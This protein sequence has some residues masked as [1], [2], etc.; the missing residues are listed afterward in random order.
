MTQSLRPAFDFSSEWA[1]GEGFASDPRE[2]EVDPPRS[3]ATFN[4]AHVDSMGRTALMRAAKVG[5]YGDALGL[6]RAGAD[7][8]ALDQVGR[9]ALMLAIRSCAGDCVRLLLPVTK[10]DVRNLRGQSAL[11]LARRSGRSDI[12]A[13][14][15]AAEIFGA[16]SGAG[17]RARTGPRL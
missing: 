1:K 3:E 16:I 7:P 2:G 5:C 12:Q 10:M 8:N 11:D 13:M 4:D 6:L 9:N 17:L 14:A 15:E